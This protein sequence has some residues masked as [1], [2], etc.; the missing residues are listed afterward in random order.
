MKSLDREVEVYKND[1]RR[2]RRATVILLEATVPFK[3]WFPFVLNAP[4]LKKDGSINTIHLQPPHCQRRS[5]AD[6]IYIRD[7]R[8]LLFKESAHSDTDNSPLG[9]G[10][11]FTA[12]AYSKGLSDSPLNQTDYYFSLDPERAGSRNL[13]NVWARLQAEEVL[14]EVISLNSSPP[15]GGAASGLRSAGRGP[16]GLLR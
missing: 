3:E 14:S 4:L 11:L 13:Y 5:P 10:F 2:A 1:I 16:R 15:G 12:I 9:E 6:G 8:C 7:P